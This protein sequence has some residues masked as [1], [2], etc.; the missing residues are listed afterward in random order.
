MQNWSDSK[1]KTWTF[2]FNINHLFAHSLNCFKYNFLR[3]I[4]PQPPP[5]L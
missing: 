4:N 5:S 2:Q 1:D 3:T